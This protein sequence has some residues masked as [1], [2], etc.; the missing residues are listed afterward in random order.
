MCMST[1]KPP[2]PPPPP[3]PKAVP[4]LK[5]PAA[6]M[7]ALATQNGRRRKSGSG[8]DSLRIDRTDTK[9]NGLNL[10]E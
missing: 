10:P 6:E 4:R 5:D 2:S 8:L 1:P 3:A 7:Q 9:S